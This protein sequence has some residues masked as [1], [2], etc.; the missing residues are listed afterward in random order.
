MSCLSNAYRLLCEFKAA[1]PH[2][3]RKLVLAQDLDGPRS[4]GH[5]MALEGLCM[6]HT[7]LKAFPTARKAITEALAIL[8][9]LGLHQHEHYGSM[10]MGL[11]RLDCEQGRYREAL[12]IYNKAKALLAQYKEGS[13]YGVLLTDM[14]TCHEKLHEWNEAVVLRKEVVEHSRGLHGDSHPEYA[15]ALNNLAVLFY[16]LKQFEE[17]ILRYEE[18]LPIYQRVYGDKHQLTVGVAEDL[19]TT[20]QL[21]Q[22][23]NRDVINAG[24]N[25]SMCNQCGTVKEH[26][27]K[28]DGC[29]RAW[30]C[31]TDCQL[32]H[33]PT[34][35]PQCDV[36]IQCATVL[37]KIMRCSRCKKV[38][39]CGAECSKA[40]WSEHK[41]DCVR[42]A[43]NIF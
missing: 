18:A 8:D 23:R 40:H 33:W 9:E 21:A 17:A 37:T 31:N 16:N 28:C 35:R 2:A 1:L 3:E 27:F 30:Y 6:V 32:Q 14:A 4:L 38:K 25:Y 42:R 26:M 36:C 43:L 34:H 15:T 24:H 39:Y 41:K 5:A 29:N 20:R 12:V 13:C 10:L 19:A 22:Q 7:A 11:G